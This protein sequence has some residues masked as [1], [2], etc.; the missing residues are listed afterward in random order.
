[1][2]RAIS[3][4]IT[5]ATT[6]KTGGQRGHD[7]RT[8]RVPG[9]VD[10]GRTPKNSVILQ[11]ITAAEARRRC[12][13]LRTQAGARRRMRGN[14]A[15]TMSGIIT[16]GTEAQPIIEGLG[17]DEQ[18]VIFR[19]VAESCAGI[20]QTDLTG[21]VVHRDE[22]AIH[23]HFQTLAR[24]RDGRP[25]S[26]IGNIGA[27]LQNAA[28][29]VVAHLGIERGTPRIVRQQRGEPMSRWV[30]R[31]VRQ[32]HTDLPAEIEAA[33]AELTRAE[34]R[35]EATQRRIQRLG[36]EEGKLAA[37]LSR[38]RARVARAEAELARLASIS[39]ADLPKPSIVEISEPRPGLL[40]SLGFRRYRRAR[41]LS[42][43]E[44]DA[45]ARQRVQAAR[46]ARQSAEESRRARQRAERHARVLEERV[47]ALTAKL[48][49][50]ELSQPEIDEKLGEIY[51]RVARKLHR[52]VDPRAATETQIAECTGRVRPL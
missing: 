47:G 52:S 14:A 27:A 44:I 16:F 50:Y 36:D 31:S 7:L 1:M 3:V 8:G 35:A 42:P 26:K 19:R 20:M 49:E 17:L 18:D 2:S 13:I 15:V 23:A 29:E 48:S 9:Y 33:R 34:R 25:V 28:A 22:S 38:Q 43:R 45:W 12:E 21:L 32:L 6:A 39:R 37:R 11:P 30:H 46:G 5:T 40:G 4:R 41:M 51:A 10:Q 24:T